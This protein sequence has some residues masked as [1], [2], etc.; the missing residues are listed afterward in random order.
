MKREFGIIG[1]PLH[2]SASPAFFNKKFADEGIDA[3]YLP[4]EIENIEELPRILAQ[5]PTLCGFNVTI[6]YKLQ[7]MN[8]LE[9]MS[10]EAKGIMAVNVVKVTRDSDGT[11][12]LHG[13][14]SDVI[15]FTRSLEPLTKGR[16]NKALIL[17]T[18]GVSKAVAY[19]LQALGIEY[20]LVSR[21]SGNGAIAY[22]EITPE[23][24]HSHT[25]L[26][27]C[28]P[29]GM[30]GHGVDKCPDIPYSLLTPQH[31]LYDVV[32]NP[33][34]TLFLRKGAE[35]GAETKSGYEMWY[36]QALA[37]WEIWNS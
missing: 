12:H 2:Q 4:F 14:N 29:L 21:K 18:G 24:M 16:H 27:N 32:Y 15:G 23:I 13:Y 26:V 25:L 37:S 31:L 22:D 1:Y 36:L 10:D 5:H 3:Q 34:E 33:E 35:Q 8:Y 6:P 19:S 11:P 28:T 20:L 17:G 7:V 30:V 9:D